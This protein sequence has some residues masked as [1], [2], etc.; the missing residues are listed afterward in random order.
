MKVLAIGNSFSEDAMRYLHFIAKCDNTDLMCVNLMIGGCSL[1]THHVNMLSDK[2]AYGLQFNGQITGFYV[3]L[4]EALLAHEWDYITIQQASHFSINYDT[5]EPYVKEVIDFARKCVPKAKI[6]IHQTWAYEE[7]S[8]R[9]CNELGYSNQADM[10]ADIEKAYKK[11]TKAINADLVIP[12]GALFQKLLSNGIEKIH[13]DTFHAK[14][15]LGRYALGLLW[16]SMLTGNDIENNTFCS[17][18]EEVTKEEIEI[19]KKCVKEVVKEY[20]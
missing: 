2:K 3:T 7:G 8:K 16:Y 5:Y 17:F 14:L 19:I 11:A 1:R 10:F 18:D 4:K 9:L 15:G 6:A 13:R 20:E 12:S